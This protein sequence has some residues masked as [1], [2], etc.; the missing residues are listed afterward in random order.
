MSATSK[1]KH[2]NVLDLAR[3]YFK[4]LRQEVNNGEV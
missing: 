1:T 4:R 3:E 2:E